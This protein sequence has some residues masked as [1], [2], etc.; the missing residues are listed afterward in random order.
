[1]PYSH[2]IE[3][4]ATFQSVNSLPSVSHEP[5]LACR[6]LHAAL[7]FEDGSGGDSH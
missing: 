1:M 2:S 3:F 5:V 6:F 4:E 7:W